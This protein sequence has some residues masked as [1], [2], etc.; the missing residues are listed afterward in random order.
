MNNHEE[1]GEEER[2]DFIGKRGA[3][4]LIVGAIG[5]TLGE[6]WALLKSKNHDQA[7]DELDAFAKATYLKPVLGIFGIMK[8][9]YLEK[10]E[11]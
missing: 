9:Y 4:L 3:W 10:Y 6:T 1:I 5:G 8:A 11:N 2:K 7:V